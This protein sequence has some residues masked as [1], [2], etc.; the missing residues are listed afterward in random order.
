[1]KNYLCAAAYV[2]VLWNFFLDRLEFEELALEQFFGQ[3]YRDFRCKVPT[4][5]PFLDRA[6]AKRLGQP[7]DTG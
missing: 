2:Y 1:M 5:I 6:L 3:E 4:R 7:I